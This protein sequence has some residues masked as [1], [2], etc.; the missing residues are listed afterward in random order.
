MNPVYA[1]APAA[2]VNPTD[3]NRAR[4]TAMRQA[5]RIRARSLRRRVIAGALALFV[6]AWVMI[7][8]VLVSGHDPALAAKKTTA[9]ASAP[10]STSSSNNSSGASSVSTHQS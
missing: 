4:A 2:T 9:V 7:T 6:A 8:V 1:G 5:R 3:A 10:A